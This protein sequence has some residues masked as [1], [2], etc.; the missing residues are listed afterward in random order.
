MWY[1]MFVG[2]WS[3]LEWVSEEMRRNNF[4]Y[5]LYRPK[6][7]GKKIRREFVASTWLNS[8]TLSTFPSDLSRWSWSSAI[9]SCYK[10][11]KL[12]NIASFRVQ[13]EHLFILFIEEG[14]CFIES[15]MNNPSAVNYYACNSIQKETFPKTGGNSTVILKGRSWFQSQ[16][17]EIR[18]LAPKKGKGER[19]FINWRYNIL[20][21]WL[22]ILLMK[23]KTIKTVISNQN[24]STRRSV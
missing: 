19:K 4:T 24:F 6:K 17:T 5:R 1:V 22:L 9:I 12:F 21:N 13:L 8:S 3:H 23:V 15:A 18:S 14:C 16:N 2:V 20:K 7:K 11:V 10:Y